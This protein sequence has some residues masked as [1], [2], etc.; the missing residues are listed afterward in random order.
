MPMTIASN[1]L[2]EGN[3]MDPQSTDLILQEGRLPVGERVPP[4]WRVTTGN[5]YN[6]QAFRIAYRYEI[7]EWNDA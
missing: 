5:M 3:P 4:N 6:S 7:E 2:I 1:R